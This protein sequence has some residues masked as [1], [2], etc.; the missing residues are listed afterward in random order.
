MRL[1]RTLRALA[2]TVLAG[3]VIQGLPAGTAQAEVVADPAS[4][5]NPFIGTSGAGNTFPG[6]DVPFGMVQWSPDTWNPNGSPWDPNEK[7][8]WGGGYRYEDLLLKGY[9][10]THL[11]GPGCGG[12]GDVPILPTVGTVDLAAAR[13]LTTG[14]SH[15]NESAGAGNYALTTNDG[16]KTELTATQRT[17]MSRF[18]FPATAARGNLLFKL[19][20]SQTGSAN[21]A[22]TWT[23]VG[24]R[25]ITGTVTTGRFCGFKTYKIHFSVTF[26]RPFTSAAF[27]AGHGAALTFDT[28]ND[29]V[30]HAKA[31]VSYVSVAGARGNVAAEN[32]GW[33][34][35]AVKTAAH[36]TWNNVL[37][38][39]GIAG[40]TPAQQTMF[41]TALYHSLLHPNVVSDSDGKYQGF[42]NAVHTVTPGHSAQYGTISGWD[43]Y[44][45]QAQL[46]A[47][48]APS[49]ASDIAQ[50]MVNTYAQSGMLPKWSLNNIETFVMVG[51]P[52]AV[53]L[54]DYHAFGATDFDTTAARNAM[55]NQATTPNNIRPG[56]E[57][58]DTYGYL[59]SN[60][61]Q[62][63]V[64][65]VTCSTYP[66]STYGNVST[67]LE[68][69]TAD[70]AVAAFAGA[71]GDTATRT[72]LQNRAQNWRNLFNPASGFM[73]PRI[74]GGAWAGA[75]DPTTPRG[76]SDPNGLY[77]FVEGTS[78]QYTGMVPFNIAGLSSA[79]GGNAKLTQYL[80]G[81][82]SEL[83]GA[84]GRA[85]L[86]NE[87]SIGLPWMYDYVGAPHKTQQTVRR[88]QNELW[89]NNPWGI[90]SNDDL[91]TM[92]AWYVWSALGMYPM[93]PGTS[94]L[95]LGSPVFTQAVL[96][97]PSGNTLTINAPGAA[98]DAPYVQSA[99]FN[100]AAWNNAYLPQNA[101]TSGGTFGYTL[102]TSPNT[103]WASAPSAAPPSYG[104]T[105]VTPPAQ[106]PSG[107][108][109]SD[110]PGKCVDVDQS[111]Q[112][113]GTAVQLWTC[114]NSAAQH[115][116]INADK[117]VTALG[118]CLDV[119]SGGTANETKV[120]LWQCNGGAAQQ[121]TYDTT[122]K[123][124]RN[125]ASGRCLD[126]PGGATADGTRLQIYD[127]NQTNAQRWTAP[128]S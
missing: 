57:H 122:A 62:N 19:D 107:P 111:S 79:F 61:A 43:I 83:R 55:V 18:T 64:N 15:A 14:Y 1:R 108:I 118:K 101:I 52:G 24:D 22:P 72:R 45:T 28:T 34:F 120:Q 90:P 81:V 95:A 124:F 7:N 27:T 102:G 54:A 50:S 26:D 97:L 87:H 116:T 114:N 40:G 51:D 84:G 128:Q 16:I 36:S 73:Q 37:G 85:D 30:V 46:N 12:A 13:D 115:W 66:Y 60:A 9:S 49:V 98:T 113:N 56:V 86:G 71:T 35:G 88:V 109:T 96:T 104:G 33:D 76:T 41:Y 77:D 8:P 126:V 4:L 78:W 20:R 47:L 48:V 110:L 39:I 123:A 99:T 80:D 106:G 23:T 92:S 117:T 121:W 119:V 103:S 67:S 17:G 100:G 112:A 6:A 3:T 38:R 127:C 11:S 89:S 63:C 91:G 59:P 25:E 2:A 10:L 75:F 29:K 21:P 58:L 74:A 125:P 105:P 44:R 94:D 82:L 69:N 42:D 5:V 31:G 68:Y 65:G 32:P 93:T 53:L 70:F